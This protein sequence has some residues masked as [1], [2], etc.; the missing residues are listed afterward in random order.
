MRKESFIK[1]I[2]IDHD[3]FDITL[4]DQDNNV[5][6]KSTL[7]AGESELLVLSIIWGTIHSSRKEIPVV[8][9]TLLGRLDLEHKS[10]VINNLIPQFGKQC[11]ILATNSEITKDLFEDLSPYIA[12]HYT[13]KYNANNKNTLIEDHFFNRQIKGETL[14]EF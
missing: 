5:I 13:L 2:N 3:T 11:I 4:I 10:S 8:L 6:N 7:S 14:H 9:D 12:N 1:K